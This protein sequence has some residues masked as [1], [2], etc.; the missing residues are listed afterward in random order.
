MNKQCDFNK[1]VEKANHIHK[2]KYTY[3][4]N[5]FISASKR[6]EIVCSKHGIF[7]KIGYNHLRIESKGS[8]C[9]LCT[10]EK[11]QITSNKFY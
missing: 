9:P 3:V 8:G 11:K 6:V 2:N 5:T 1:F 10:K 7:E 4:E